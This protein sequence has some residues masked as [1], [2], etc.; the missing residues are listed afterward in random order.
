MNHGDSS[1]SQELFREIQEAAKVRKPTVAAGSGSSRWSIPNYTI[2]HEIH[3]GGQGVV[4]KA[5][6]DSTKRTVA[7]KFI[8][9][10][11]FAT[12]R[13]R[14]R[15]EREIDLASRLNHRNI[16]TVFD[17]GIADNQPFCAMEFVDG[18]TLNAMELPSVD[19]KAALQK[20]I[21]LFQ[22]ICA[23]VGYAHSRGVIHRDIKPANI[24]VDKGGEPRILDFG[25]A[26]V[27]DAETIA[28][29]SPRTMTGEFVGTLSYASPEQAKANPELTDTRSDVYSLG[30]VFYEMLTGRLPYDVSGPLV[31]TLNHIT[32]TDPI[33]P[34][35][36]RAGLN[37]DI[38]TILLKAL[39]KDPDRRYQ[40]ASLMADDLQHYLR[41]EPIDA[42]R[43]S[44]WYVLKKNLIRHKRV[45][46]ATLSFIAVLVASLI[47]IT[48]FYWQA[49]DERDA[50]N[51]AK[52][53]EKKLRKQEGKQ[54]KLAE[55]RTYVARIAAADA[56]VRNYATHDV[57]KNLYRTPPQHRGWEYWYVFGRNNLSLTTLGFANRKQYGHGDH[58][59]SVDYHAKENWIVSGSRDGTIVFWNPVDETIIGRHKLKQSI[60]CVRFHPN[61]QSIAVGFQN[62][63]AALLDFE[64]KS[65]EQKIVVQDSQKI[66]P[67]DGLYVHDLD[68][69]P[70]GQQILIGAGIHQKQGL[71]LIYEVATQK[72]IRQIPNPGKPILSVAWSDDGQLFATADHTI[73]IWNAADGKPVHRLPGHDSWISALDFRPDGKHLVSCANEPIVKIWGVESGKYLKSLYGHTSFVSFVEYSPDSQLIATG[74]ADSTLRIWNAR[75]TKP[76]SVQWGQYSGIF[77]V[78]FSH[79][80]RFVAT[81]GVWSVKTWNSRLDDSER[82][83]V[84]HHQKIL[85]VE[86]S[87]DSKSL[88]TCD[89]RGCVN[90]WDLASRTLKHRICEMSNPA[91]AVRSVAYSPDGRFAAWAND[92]GNV[93]LRDL[94][95]LSNRV[96]RGHGESVTSV[97]FSADSL[98]LYSS[99]DAQTVRSWNVNDGESRLFC[100]TESKAKKVL[101]DPQ[102][103]WII[104]AGEHDIAVYDAKSANKV[105]SWQRKRDLLAENFDIAVHPDGNQLVASI[106]NNSA[107]VWSIPGGKPLGRLIEHSQSIQSVTYTP[108]G[109]RIATSSREGTI[110]IW[111]LQHFQVVLTIQGFSGYGE[112]IDFSPDNFRL[113]G[114]M[115]DGSLKTWDTLAFEK[116]AQTNPIQDSNKAV[117]Q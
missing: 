29:F 97:C 23:A 12:E 108:D 26:K 9:H 63:D 38:E 90:Q 72:L 27:I 117:S 37:M 57:L 105:A 44:S 93:Y 28:G 56:S 64:M 101:A 35:V 70:D 60:K 77:E 34:S 88:L 68:F 54:R 6:Q 48:I 74:S 31:E 25:L 100:Q 99:S 21:E 80:S 41:G 69:S 61:Q 96:L 113:V 14:F 8:L 20:Q 115:Y 45:A 75:N 67:T 103:K 87:P 83:G 110:K 91:C 106:D 85:D 66:F 62:G 71:A 42:R 111:D 49:V 16:V 78:S 112:A 53:N 10:G 19:P 5:I 109:K 58:V 59:Y 92:N 46:I 36:S 2:L 22:K 104:V 84:D 30:V 39:A 32:S 98:T 65:G 13:Q 102:G 24:L 51:L 89:N 4:F 73:T 50:A 15:F 94:T 3:R 76:L 1:D 114:G 79:D 86:I 43:D 33:L 52:N 82:F 11:S 40:N 107:G 81:S 55:F 95:K 18:T 17:G 47:A 7:L 116:R